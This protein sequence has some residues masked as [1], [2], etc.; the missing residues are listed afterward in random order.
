VQGVERSI[1]SPKNSMRTA[2]LLVH[3]E[4]LDGVAPHPEGAA[5][6]GEVV[7]LVLHLDE[8]RSSCRVDLLADPQRDHRSTYSCGVPRP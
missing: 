7:A 2:V 6:E 5:G 4:D 3:R 1:S 8:R